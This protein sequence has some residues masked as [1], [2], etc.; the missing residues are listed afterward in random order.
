MISYIVSYPTITFLWQTRMLQISC[1][2]EVLGPQVSEVLYV[3]HCLAKGGW[4]WWLKWRTDAKTTVNSNQNKILET[5][6]VCNGQISFIIVSILSFGL[7]G[8]QIVHS[9]FLELTIHLVQSLL[10]TAILEDWISFLT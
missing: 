5:F 8:N 3:S 1:G 10:T 2:M 4:T 6:A 9:Y 7:S